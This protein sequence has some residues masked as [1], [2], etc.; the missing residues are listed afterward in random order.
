MSWKAGV[1]AEVIGTPDFSIGERIYMSKIYLNTAGLFS[2]TFVVILLSFL[3]ENCFLILLD[4]AAVVREKPVRLKEERRLPKEQKEKQSDICI[5]KLYKKFGEQPIFADFSMDLSGGKIYCIM[6]RSGGGKTTLFRILLGLS[7][8]Q[9]GIVQ[10]P[11]GRVAAVFQE[12]RLCL[13]ENAVVNVSMVC[14]R[15]IS[16]EAIRNILAEVLPKDELGK[17]VGEFSGGMRRR[18]AIVRALLADAE[19]LIMDEP[20]TGLDEK[21]KDNLIQFILKYRKDRTLLVATHQESDVETLGANLI[22]LP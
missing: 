18:V 12:D 16:E 9:K 7:E 20:F 17:K 13:H 2:W 15:T 11:V 3:F 21:T 10:K 5:E 14:N 4:K 8:Y 19:W 1:A 6:G 22:K